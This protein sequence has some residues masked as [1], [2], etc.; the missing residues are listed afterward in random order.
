MCE[1]ESHTAKNDTQLVFTF[2][3]HLSGLPPRSSRAF[4]RESLHVCVWGALVCD[5]A[6]NPKD[7]I[8][9]VWLVVVINRQ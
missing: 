7:I 9:R 3:L 8:V 6:A 4:A 5:G 1:I 2:P